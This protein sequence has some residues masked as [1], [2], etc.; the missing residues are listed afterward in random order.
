MRNVL[1]LVAVLFSATLVHAAPPA[2]DDPDLDLGHDK[3]DENPDAGDSDADVAAAKRSLAKYLDAV[4]EKRWDEAKKLTHPAAMEMIAGIKKRM[5]K[6]E[7]ALAPWAKVKEL[8][9][10]VW[11]ITGARKSEHGPIVVTALE[12]H[13]HVAEKGTSH[14]DKAAY[15]LV[16]KGDAWL[17]ADKK[18]DLDD[19]PDESIKFGYKGYFEMPAAASPAE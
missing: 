7:H 15:L 2:R 8:T 12:D 16:K 14:E 10:A 5:K 18:T 1:F 6:E 4:K 11:K 17:V 13:F 9:L 19:I 3:A